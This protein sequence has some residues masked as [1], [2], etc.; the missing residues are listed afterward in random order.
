MVSVLFD[1]SSVQEHGVFV[2]LVSLF[3][4]C[5][6]GVE[7][8]LEVLE[9]VDI[10]LNLFA[11]LF[12]VATDVIAHNIWVI[13]L[14]FFFKSLEVTLRKVDVGNLRINLDLSNDTG[15]KHGISS[16]VNFCGA[17]SP[18]RVCRALEEVWVSSIFDTNSIPASKFNY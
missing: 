14:S 1:N 17:K 12:P 7:S 15:I 3:E 16:K 9:L 2:K 6:I 4:I 18:G 11:C 10:F 5:L 8:D 13:G